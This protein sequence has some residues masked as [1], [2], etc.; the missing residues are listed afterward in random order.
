VDVGEGLPSESFEQLAIPHFELYNFASWLTHDRQETEDLVQE[1]YAKAL[2][3]ST[4]CTCGYATQLFRNWQ[5]QG[6]R[7]DR[8]CGASHT[9]S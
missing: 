7:R 3:R 6:S 1:T 4:P 8:Y 2:Y 9:R 5:R